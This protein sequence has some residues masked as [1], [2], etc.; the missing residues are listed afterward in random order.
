[1]PD[2]PDTWFYLLAPVVAAL[3]YFGLRA[4]PS[5]QAEDLRAREVDD[6]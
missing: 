5:E 4:P 3:L 6:D 1:M 2:L